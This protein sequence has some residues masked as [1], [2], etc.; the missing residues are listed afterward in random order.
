[1]INRKVLDINLQQDESKS[2]SQKE[3]IENKG[4]LNKKIKRWWI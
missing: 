1:M 4:Q 2:I 3:W